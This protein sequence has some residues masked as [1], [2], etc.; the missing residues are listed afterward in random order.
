MCKRR[1]KRTDWRASW[2]A[3]LRPSI[4]RARYELNIPEVVDAVGR[5]VDR[6]IPVVTVVTDLPTS[7][8]LAYVGLDNLPA[9]ASTL[10]QLLSAIDR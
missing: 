9:Q 3:V 1:R 4:F 8:R 5:L 6:S 10:Q 2:H 7:R